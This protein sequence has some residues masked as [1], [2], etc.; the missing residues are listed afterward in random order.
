M[1][2]TLFQ[3]LSK[4]LE[5]FERAV[6]FR[7]SKKHP[8]GSPQRH[9][10]AV[11]S[12]QWQEYKKTTEKQQHHRRLPSDS[13]NT[14]TYEEKVTTPSSPKRV[15]SLHIPWSP[16]RSL[17]FFKSLTSP[18]HSTVKETMTKDEKQILSSSYSKPA[19]PLNAAAACCSLDNGET[20]PLD[21]NPL[22]DKL[23]AVSHS[24]SDSQIAQSKL[25]LESTV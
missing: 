8:R 21:P 11:D 2:L 5:R 19:P 6:P 15:P 13:R 7:K 20:S 25:R 14:I 1:F 23:N 16:I 4:T 22:D 9:T 17:K 3:K 18:R 24:A 10:V 12:V